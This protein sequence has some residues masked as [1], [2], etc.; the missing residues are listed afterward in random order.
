MGPEIL[1][2]NTLPSENINAGSWTTL[3]S[4]KDVVKLVT[5]LQISLK[6]SSFSGSSV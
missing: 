1:I 3:L 2:V 4:D 6:F 5:H